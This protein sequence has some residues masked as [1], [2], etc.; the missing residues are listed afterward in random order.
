VFGEEVQRFNLLQ[1]KTKEKAGSGRK[2]GL[3]FFSERLGGPQRQIFFDNTLLCPLATCKGGIYKCTLHFKVLFKQQ[4][5][6][7]W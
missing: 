4:K 7:S 3:Y 6:K 1:G 5:S 2:V